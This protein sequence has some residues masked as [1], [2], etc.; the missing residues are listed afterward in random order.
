MRVKGDRLA[1]ERSMG[2][3]ALINSRCVLN[4]VCVCV[5]VWKEGAQHS[6]GQHWMG[7]GEGEGGQT[8]RERA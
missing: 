3:A 7:L 4:S 8:A 2:R 1:R 6:T 5:C